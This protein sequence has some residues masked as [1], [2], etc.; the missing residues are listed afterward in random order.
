MASALP[1]AKE[2][3]QKAAQ[4]E[5]E[6]AAEA[7]RLQAK[8]EAEKQALIEPRSTLRALTLGELSI[9]TNSAG[10]ALNSVGRTRSIVASRS[11]MSRGF[12]TSATG[13]PA[14]NA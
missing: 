10:T 7:M 8:A 12:G 3:M 6:K 13:V 14:T 9:A 1:S 5:G 4:K 2:L 11:S